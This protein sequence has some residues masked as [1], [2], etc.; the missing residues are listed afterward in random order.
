MSFVFVGYF[1]FFYTLH[2]TSVSPCWCSVPMSYPTLCNP[3][4]C[5][6]P[7]F[8]V[9]PYLSKFPQTHGHWVDDAIQPSHPQSLTS[10]TPLNLSQHQGFFQWLSSLH[11]VARVLI[12]FSIDWFDLIAAEGTLKSLLQHQN[13]KASIL[14]CSAFIV[15]P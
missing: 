1:T 7:G 12:I 14:R 8:P 10:P 15:G 13:S 6:M 9:L 3:M 2:I 5:R 11:Q 4:N